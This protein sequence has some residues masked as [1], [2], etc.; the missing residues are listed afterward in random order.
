MRFE[1]CDQGNALSEI[2]DCH[3]YR[4]DHDGTLMLL[5]DSIAGTLFTIHEADQI[6]AN[7]HKRSTSRLQRRAASYIHWLQRG[8]ESPDYVIQLRGHAE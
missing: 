4:R 3:V 5:S 8:D 7:Y 6:G 2:C 1:E